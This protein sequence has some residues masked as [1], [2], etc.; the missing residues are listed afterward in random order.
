M[1]GTS[2]ERMDRRIGGQFRLAF[3]EFGSGAQIGLAAN[4][5]KLCPFG[6]C[7]APTIL[8]TLICQR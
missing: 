1:A 7:V 8:M 2:I 4:T 6:A 5:S 3:I